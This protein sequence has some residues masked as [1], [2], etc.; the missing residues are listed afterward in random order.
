MMVKQQ[1]TWL[2]QNCSETKTA[3]YPL[4]VCSARFKEKC[5]S[6]A[7]SCNKASF[8]QTVN[9]LLSFQCRSKWFCVLLL[10]QPTENDTQC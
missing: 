8:Q 2:K 4:A 1:L 7:M 9:K 5:V 6:S 10:S 3:V